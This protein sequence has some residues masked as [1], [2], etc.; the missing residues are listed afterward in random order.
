MKLT[1]RT[2]FGVKVPLEI[3]D[4]VKKCYDKGLTAEEAEIGLQHY[5]T[6]RTAKTYLYVAARFYNIPREWRN[7][8]L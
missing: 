6:K 3:I 8:V 1:W 7:G 2:L 4:E 5:Y